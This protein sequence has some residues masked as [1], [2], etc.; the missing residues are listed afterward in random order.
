MWIDPALPVTDED[1]KALKPLFSNYQ[2]WCKARCRVGEIDVLKM[3]YIELEGKARPFII[4]RLK[5]RFDTLRNARELRELNDARKGSRTALE[6]AS[7]G[8]RGPVPEVH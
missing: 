5:H 4:T 6:E 7:D 3:I 2:N 8:A 1:R